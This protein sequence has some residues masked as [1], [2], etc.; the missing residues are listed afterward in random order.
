[1]KKLLAFLLIASI[2]FGS[3]ACT[4]KKEP[5]AATQTTAPAESAPQA[6][7]SAATTTTAADEQVTITLPESFF[8]N[9]N[10]EYDD[11][12]KYQVTINQ[13]GSRSITMSKAIHTEK[14][15]EIKDTVQEF[16][17]KTKSS[18]DSSIKDIITSDD[19]TH[20]TLVVDQ[21]QYEESLDG[22]VVIGF[23]LSSYIYQLYDGVPEADIRL[24]V[25]VQDAATQTV[26][27]TVVYPD[28]LNV[29]DE[30]ET[31]E[32]R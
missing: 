14:L 27:D 8:G 23:W 5:E 10:G 16:F 22:F 24:Q 30:T 11:T 2:C 12:S 17:D 19:L 28:D 4:A 6:Q 26:F 13:D 7:A 9:D 25:D 32:E 15:N 18:E 1:M 31:T 29:D 20:M 21:A 3:V